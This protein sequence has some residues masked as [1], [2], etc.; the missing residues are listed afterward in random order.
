MKKHLSI[1]PRVAQPQLWNTH[2]DQPEDRR[3]TLIQ[4]LNRQ[5][6]DLIDL[7]LQAKQA[8]WN[9]KGPHFTS[10]HALFDEVAGSLGGLTD[11]LAERAVMLGGIARGT[12]QAIS[13]GSRLADYPLDAL[14]GRD[15]LWA[16]LSASLA[17]FAQS[18][19]EAIASA[20][21]TGDAVTV[22]LLTQISRRVDTLLWKVEAHIALEPDWSRNEA[23]PTRAALS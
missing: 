17:R 8:H 22:D 3:V 13:H 11:D 6:A 21:D 15:H 2:H 14:D 16:L 12:L 10:L 20:G 9:V 5:L 7:G 1:T 23:V 19:R 18:S 4:L